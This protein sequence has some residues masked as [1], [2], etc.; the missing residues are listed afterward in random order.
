M[1]NY[2]HRRSL[3]CNPF[4][5]DENNGLNFCTC[6]HSINVPD[7]KI[8]EFFFEIETVYTRD[9]LFTSSQQQQP[10]K[11]LYLLMDTTF[12]RSRE[13]SAHKRFTA[14]LKHLIRLHYS[15]IIGNIEKNIRMHSCKMPLQWPSW[16]RG[17][18]RGGGSAQ[19]MSA[20]GVCLP[21]GCLP[22]GVSA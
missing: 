8:N 16:K 14:K 21:R 6:E 15:F 20:G 11:E 22:R 13:L 7:V 1:C 19:G 3:P 9:L 10:V 5:I 18:C 17:V 2:E 12:L 4:F